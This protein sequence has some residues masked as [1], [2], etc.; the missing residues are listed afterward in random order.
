[1]RAVGSGSPGSKSA[2][3]DIQVVQKLSDKVSQIIRVFNRDIFVQVE[4][5]ADISDQ[6][7]LLHPFGKR[8]MQHSAGG[9]FV[10]ALSERASG[11]P[12][13]G[14]NCFQCAAGHYGPCPRT[15]RGYRPTGLIK[16]VLDFQRYRWIVYAARKRPPMNPSPPDLAATSIVRRSGP[17]GHLLL[18]HHDA[19]LAVAAGKHDNPVV[20][21]A[22]P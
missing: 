7:N 20:M 19:L 21:N 5:G 17:T 15:V 3:Q 2:R 9:Q 6:S 14:R 13:V 16:R 8:W 10:E 22:T 12:F 18:D 4:M 11:F 1:L